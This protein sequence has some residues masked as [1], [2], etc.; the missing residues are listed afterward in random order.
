MISCKIF[1]NLLEFFKIQNLN[2]TVYA[3]KM[4]RCNCV[5]GVSVVQSHTLV[6]VVHSW[7]QDNE[8]RVL[9]YM[10]YKDVKNYG[11]KYY[12]V[13]QTTDCKPLSLLKKTKLM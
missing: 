9:M 4:A 10:F 13:F 8:T 12:L 11:F 5:Y 3:G 1:I 6:V 7:I 2:F